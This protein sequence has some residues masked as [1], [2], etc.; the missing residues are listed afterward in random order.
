[1]R[2]G[3]CLFSKAEVRCGLQ[4]GAKQE[5]KLGQHVAHQVWAGVREWPESGERLSVHPQNHLQGRQGAEWC[6]ITRQEAKAIPPHL[7]S[8][9]ESLLLQPWPL[10]PVDL[11]PGL[12]LQPCAHLNA[13]VRVSWC[14]NE[15]VLCEAQP[16]A[17]ERNQCLDP[18]LSREGTLWCIWP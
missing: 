9:R 17:R 13:N 12:S 7:L 2:E 10:T 4:L 3:H 18:A 14:L 1:M 15:P 8:P 16:A 11:C 5:A 6:V